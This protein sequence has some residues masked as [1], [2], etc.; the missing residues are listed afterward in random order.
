MSSRCC[1]VDGAPTLKTSMIWVHSEAKPSIGWLTLRCTDAVDAQMTKRDSV[2]L[3]PLVQVG[4]TY[5][6]YG[7]RF[8]CTDAVP[9]PRGSAYAAS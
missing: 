5:F 1:Q 9:L 2:S 3:P 4:A 6:F 7:L 8:Y